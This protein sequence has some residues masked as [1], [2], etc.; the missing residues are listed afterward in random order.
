[1]LFFFQ[2][3]T[4]KKNV[5]KVL[6]LSKLMK[7]SVLSRPV[8]HQGFSVFSVFNLQAISRCLEI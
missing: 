4:E 2:P 1:M 8:M 6:Q 5:L 3:E 7:K